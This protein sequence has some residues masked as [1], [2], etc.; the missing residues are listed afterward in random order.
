M[1]NE[2]QIKFLKDNSLRIQLDIEYSGEGRCYIDIRDPEYSVYSSSSKI[3]EI[4]MEI[5]SMIDFLI[6]HDEMSDDE[7]HYLDLDEYFN[8]QGGDIDE[9]SIN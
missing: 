3:D 4:E 8:Y 9:E 2:K 5:I 6:D 1:L 7:S